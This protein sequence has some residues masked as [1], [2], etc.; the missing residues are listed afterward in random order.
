MLLPRL[1]QFSPQIP[2][3]ENFEGPNASIAAAAPDLRQSLEFG[4]VEK[5][6]KH[7]D[8]FTSKMETERNGWTCIPWGECHII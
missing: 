6:Q 4:K 7:K 5:S 2:E 1:G 3:L 8:I